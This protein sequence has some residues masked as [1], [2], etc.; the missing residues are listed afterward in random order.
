MRAIRI[1][2]AVW[3]EIAKRGVFGETEDDVL[4]RIFEIEGETPPPENEPN[5]GGGPPA[6]VRSPPSQYSK[7]EGFA[8]D[9]MHA[10][11][12]SGNSTHYLLVSFQDGSV[13]DQWDLPADCSDKASIRA[14]MNAA[15][16]FGEVNGASK[17]QIMAIRKAL[18]DA[19]Y[20]LTK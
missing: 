17:G 19:G 16:D 6:A 15:L 5:L 10:R 14:V 4:K 12:H 3:Q 11:V 1:S 9:K 20:H 2:E 18:T 8:T 7:R 13:R